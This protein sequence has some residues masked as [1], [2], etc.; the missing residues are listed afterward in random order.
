MLKRAVAWS[1][2]VWVSLSS[3][4]SAGIVIDRPPFNTGGPGAD[5]SFIYHSGQVLWQQSAD[6]FVLTQAATVRHVTWWGFYGDDFESP[7]EQPPAT[8]TMQFRVYGARAQ[9]G[10]PG[11]VLFEETLVDPPYAWNGRQ[12]LTGAAPKEY[13]FDVDL[14]TPMHLVATTPYWLEIVQLGL[15]ESLYRWE[16][17]VANR[18]GFAFLIGSTGDWIRTQNTPA[19]LAFQLSTIPEPQTSALVGVA[20]LVL[21]RRRRRRGLMQDEII[22]PRWSRREWAVAC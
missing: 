13:R 6:D 22:R 18:D 20:S 8:Q 17:S 7:A 11:D 16:I 1:C 21:A 2:A 5:T 3:I 15:A 4:A 9:D 14:T 12:I 19:T 10:L